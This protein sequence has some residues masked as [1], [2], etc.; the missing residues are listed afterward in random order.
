MGRRSGRLAASGLIVV[1]SSVWID[2]FND[3]PGPEVDELVRLIGAEMPVGLA[4]PC[5]T[6]ILRGCRTE[7]D[8]ARVLDTLSGFPLIDTSGPETHILAA[9]IYRKARSSGVTVRGTVDLLVAALCIENEAWLL[10]QDR[11]FI[12]L[13]K[14]SDLK[15]WEAPQG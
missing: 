2:F 5:L 12:N 15:I 8:A 11:D 13:A 10:H 1:D 4:G 9:S 7:E 6:E 14:F 3:V